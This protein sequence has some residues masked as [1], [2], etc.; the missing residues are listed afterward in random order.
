MRAPTVT[1]MVWVDA[2]VETAGSRTVQELGE[3]K[4]GTAGRTEAQ[5]SL[6]DAWAER[7]QHNPI[8]GVN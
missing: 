1:L 2:A 4:D 3:W 8:K 5:D 7:E 6:A